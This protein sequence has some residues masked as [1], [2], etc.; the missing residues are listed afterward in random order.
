VASSPP[1]ARNR[2]PMGPC[3]IAPSGT[4]PSMKPRRIPEPSLP[5]TTWAWKHVKLEEPTPPQGDSSVRRTERSRRPRRS[6]ER[7]IWIKVTYVGGPRCFFTVEA[8]GEVA[9]IPGDRALVDLM[10]FVN[11]AR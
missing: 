10:G 1:S 8:R 11:R 5:S 7:P 9:Y 4:V 6:P 3:G 2:Q